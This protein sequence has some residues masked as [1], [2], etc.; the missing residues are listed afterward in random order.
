MADNPA[1]YWRLGEASGTSAADETTNANTATY[2]N[3]PTLGVAGAL[4]DGNP[5][6][7]LDG[8]D[9][10]ASAPNTSTLNHG[11]ALTLE[12]WVKPTAGAFGSPKP[13][14]LKSFTSHTSPFYQYGLF[15]YDD[16]STKLIRFAIANGGAWAPVDKWGA[17]W[18]YGTWNH[19]VGTWDGATAR[20]YLNGT[21]VHSQSRSGAIPSYSTALTI[22]CYENLPKTSAYCFKGLVDEVA[23]YGSAISAARVQAHYNEQGT[24]PPALPPPTTAY[25]KAV[26]VDSPV[27]YWRLGDSSGSLMVDQRQAHDGVYVQPAPQL[28]QAG[29]PKGDSDTAVRFSGQ[30]AE[31]PYSSQLNP[32]VA[33]GFTIEAWVNID[34][35]PVGYQAI[36]SSRSVTGGGVRGWTLFVNN[37]PILG[38]AKFE[39]WHA[40]ASSWNTVRGLTSVEIGKWFHVVGVVEAGI[41]KLFVNGR[42]DASAAGNGFFDSNADQPTLLGTAINGN[43]ASD[44]HLLGIADELAVYNYTLSAGRILHH[45][46]EG[47][48]GELAI[49]FRPILRFSSGEDWR[50]L[51]VETFLAESFADAAPS[52]RH[53]VCPSV[54]S[55]GTCVDITSWE[56]LRSYAN[57]WNNTNKGL[58]PYIDIHGRDDTIE[59]FQT[60]VQQPLCDRTEELNDSPIEDLLMDC[61]SGAQYTSIYWHVVGPFPASNYLYLDY[62]AF[63][64]FNK[65][66]TNDHEGDWESAVVAVPAGSQDPQT[67]S[68]AAFSAHGRLW[69]YL[70]ETLYCDLSEAAG[71]CGGASQRVQAFVADGSHASYAQPC[72]VGIG[73]PQCY[74]S[75][76]STDG[77]SET[78]L[79]KEH[80]GQVRWGA[81]NDP[82]ALRQFPAD[83]GWGSVNSATWVDWWGWWG[84]GDRPYKAESPAALRDRDNF[85]RPDGMSCSERYT[86]PFTTNCPPSRPLRVGVAPATRSASPCQAWSGPYVAALACDPRLLRDALRAG[87]VDQAAPITFA[88]RAVRRRAVDAGKGV[89]QV[90]GAPLTPTARLV[91]RGRILPT[92]VIAVKVRRG[93]HTFVAKFRGLRTG[94]TRAT[95]RFADARR[96]QSIRFI[97]SGGRVFRP[98][99]VIR[100]SMSMR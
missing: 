79:E 19:V 48:G 5:A 45:Y 64:R 91:V 98:R 32:N 93:R 62:W 89:A 9:D 70:R 63:Y 17:T 27:A 14:V 54:S 13:I 99:A 41:L 26:L 6:V 34:Q 8:N 53:Q 1:A 36:A 40:G 35:L 58:W 72:D 96:P 77:A 94:A 92:T 57:G 28:A 87:T 75:D 59:N 10:H 37:N 42:L 21:Q 55:P 68:F 100:T 56:T 7:S 82:A 74:S 69:N 86:D 81:N 80:D 95:I 51:N 67:F 88:G 23:V 3:S 52:T 4:A 24:P 38:P 66:Q 25:P 39:F 61:D 11:S 20:I 73:L 43:G 85:H 33:L 16:G 83:L 78:D 90:V 49:R 30:K 60:P 15:L 44:Y 97:T 22:G 12:A 2:H 46:Q 84:F 71:S 76:G 47:I 31:V 65:A 18:A 50:P 29:A